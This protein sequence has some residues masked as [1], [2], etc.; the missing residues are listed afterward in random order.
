MTTSTNQNTMPPAT[1][2]IGRLTY[3]VTTKTAKNG[4]TVYLLEGI[5]GALYSTVRNVHTPSKVFL[6]GAGKRLRG[7]M[8]KRT[9]WL[10]DAS[11]SLEVCRSF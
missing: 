4:D 9:V 8:G 11:G 2:T 5:R 1:I 7:P 10:T 3:T 6:I